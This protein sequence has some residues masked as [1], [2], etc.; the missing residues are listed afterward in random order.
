MRLTATALLCL[1]L[2]ASEARAQRWSA[3][4]N[5]IDWAGLGTLNAEMGWGATRHF[6]VGAGMKYN[7]W[8]YRSP[9]GAEFRDKQLTA[10]LCGRW[11]PWFI[12]SGWWLQGKLQYREY[13][14]GGFSGPAT[15]E[16]DA[17]GAGLSFGYSLMLMRHLNIEF[18]AGF[19]AGCR[20]Y[21]SYACPTCGRITG[22][23]LKGFILPDNLS[24]SM[25][26]IF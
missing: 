5:V 13:N 3:S 15:E 19:W 24:V 21:V 25:Q 12:W 1:V 20:K 10:Y 7:P 23:G 11:W 14:S 18:G 8:E 16:G 22:S 2:S 4:T 9:E 6:S 26:F 17:F